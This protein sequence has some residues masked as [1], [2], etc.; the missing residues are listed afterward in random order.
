MVRI[1]VWND[2]ICPW[3]YAARP[4]TAWLVEQTADLGVDV[5]TRSFE[6]HPDLP[7][8]GRPVR[9]GSRLDQVLEHIAVECDR[10]VHP[11][12]KPL[13][14]PNSRR[15]LASA[16]WVEGR[17][18]DDDAVLAG[19]LKD[20]S[21]DPSLIDEIEDEGMRLLASARSDAMDVGATATPSWQIGE[22]VVTGLH[23]DAQFQRWIR[24]I[25]DRSA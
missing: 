5:L 17:P 15:V 6:L 7:S 22:L 12:V 4:Q 19:L 3:A 13:R 23:D 24:R 16:H 21:I 2:Y 10:R 25:L 9:P 20:S 14:T 1:T 11:F 8:E 18:I